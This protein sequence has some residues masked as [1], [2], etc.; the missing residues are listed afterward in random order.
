MALR[1]LRRRSAWRRWCAA[2]EGV[3]AGQ[4]TRADVEEHVR[5][6]HSTFTWLLEPM[7]KRSGFDILD[8]QHSEDDILASYVLRS[9]TVVVN[10]SRPPSADLARLGCR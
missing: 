7:L 2:Y 9:L 4:W 5:D 8:A 6:E 3:P 1:R 10:R